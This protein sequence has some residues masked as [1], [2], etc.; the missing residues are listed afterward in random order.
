MIPLSDTD[1]NTKPI[2]PNGAHWIIPL[3]IIVTES[4]QSVKTFLVLSLATALRA[5]PNTIDQKRIPRY[6]PSES[7][8]I[9]LENIPKIRVYIISPNP[10]GAV[11]V[12]AAER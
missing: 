3:T 6:C 11:C 4:A 2:T 7:R 10:P 8:W 1:V 9:G 12:L 5:M